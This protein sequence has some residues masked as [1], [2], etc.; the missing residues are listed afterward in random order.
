MLEYYPIHRPE[1]KEFASK[2]EAVHYLYMNSYMRVIDEDYGILL[3]RLPLSSR[4]LEMHTE[5]FEIVKYPFED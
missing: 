5:E 3:F 2:N 1:I 4:L